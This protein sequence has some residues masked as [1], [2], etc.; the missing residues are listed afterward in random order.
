[1]DTEY[2]VE[3]GSLIDSSDLYEELSDR[4]KICEELVSSRDDPIPREWADGHI[5]ALKWVRDQ[6]LCLEPPPSR[7]SSGR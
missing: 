2:K 1:M 7:A 3:H 5:E 6:L 4:I